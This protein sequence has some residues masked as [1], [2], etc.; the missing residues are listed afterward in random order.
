MDSSTGT[1][2]HRGLRRRR[3]GLYESDDGRWRVKRTDDRAWV[4]VEVV[5]GQERQVVERARSF[6][7]ARQALAAW[8][9]QSRQAPNRG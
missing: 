6:T 9:T 3:A 1:A 7:A 4:V 5:D 2:R 8:L